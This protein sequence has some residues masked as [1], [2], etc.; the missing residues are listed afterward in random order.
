[1]AFPVLQ[2]DKEFLVVGK[3]LVLALDVLIHDAVRLEHEGAGVVAHLPDAVLLAGLLEEVRWV[4]R[5][6]YDLL[7][8]QWVGEVNAQR[9]VQVL[10]GIGEVP[11][12]KCF[13]K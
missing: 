12:Q 1:M 6:L 13:I 5:L 8:L 7:W 2:E 10:D 4:D 11:V 3:I 9:D